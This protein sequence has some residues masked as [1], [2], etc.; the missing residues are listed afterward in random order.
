MFLLFAFLL[1]LF[2]DEPNLIS[3]AGLTIECT[4]GCGKRAILILKK[5]RASFQEL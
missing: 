1:P 4:E 3:Y 2:A 5:L